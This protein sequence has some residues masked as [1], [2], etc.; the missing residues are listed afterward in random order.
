VRATG[1]IPVG[2]LAYLPNSMIYI[3]Q[4]GCG[5]ELAAL[6]RFGGWRR[7]GQFLVKVTWR[8]AADVIR[9][10]VLQGA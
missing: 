8:P 5:K 3:E 7:A 6:W 4:P 9:V 2:I 1:A 10:A